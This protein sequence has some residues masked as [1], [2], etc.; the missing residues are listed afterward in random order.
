MAWHTH[1]AGTCGPAP[2]GRLTPLWLGPRWVGGSTCACMGANP[3]HVP[4]TENLAIL[5]L[6]LLLLLR[7]QRTQL[8]PSFSRSAIR[9]PRLSALWS[10]ESP[11]LQRAKRK[12]RPPSQPHFCRLLASPGT[13]RHVQ[14]HPD[15]LVD[16]LAQLPPPRRFVDRRALVRREDQQQARRARKRRERCAK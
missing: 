9:S 4:R 1:L 7:C 16:Q 5:L 11:R 15:A 8:L 10:E 6:L 14:A 12:K 3:A 13:V 2:K